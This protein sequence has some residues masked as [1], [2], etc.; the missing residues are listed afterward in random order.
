MMN[1]ADLLLITSFSET[2]PIVAKEAL[3]CNCPIISTNVGD[4]KSI[5]KK[6]DNCFVTS[7]NPNEIGEKIRI[8]LAS[9]LRSNGRIFMKSYGL[10]KVAQKIK[11]V[12]VNI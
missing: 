3:A 4:V 2:G 8:I 5:T 6:I 7:Y 1:A 9:G 12:Y 10:D 11:M